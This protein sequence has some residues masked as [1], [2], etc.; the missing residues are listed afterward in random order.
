MIGARVR[1]DESRAKGGSRQDR[2]CHQGAN[3]AATWDGARL[4]NWERK[5]SSKEAC[6]GLGVAS[7]LC[8]FGAAIGRGRVGDR[9]RGG[10]R[11]QAG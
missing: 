11:R 1:Q 3:D 4:E 6:E 2:R 9:G 8:P 5:L 7:V 10:F